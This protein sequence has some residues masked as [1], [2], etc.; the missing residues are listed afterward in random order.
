MLVQAFLLAA[1]LA[2]PSQ[3]LFAQVIPRA[4][5]YKI[6][7]SR[8]AGTQAVGSAVLIA[9]GKLIT[10]CHT[11][12]DA[13]R[14]AIIYPEGEMPVSLDQADFLHDL[15]VLGTRAFAGRP[16]TRVPSAE[17]AVGQQVVAV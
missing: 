8:M 5:V 14:I 3:S 15:C 13:K 6:G 1:L 16:V 11:V 12:R 9:P 2:F 10:N 4:S 17:L 7:V